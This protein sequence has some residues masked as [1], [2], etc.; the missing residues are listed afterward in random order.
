[1]QQIK[2]YCL[3]VQILLNMFRALQCPSSG[4]RQTAFAASGFRTNVEVEVFSAVVGLL[5]GRLTNEPWLRTLPPA[6]S[7]GNRRLQR[8]FDG[9]LMIGIVM[10]ETCWAAYVQQG[11]KFYN[12]LVHLV[13]CFI[14]EKWKVCPFEQVVLLRITE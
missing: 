2:I 8:Q 13:G 7:Y 1:M 14:R 11:N 9:L 3:V 10:P 5:V 12:W 4:A 6:H